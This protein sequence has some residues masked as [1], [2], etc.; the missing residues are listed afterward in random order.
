MQGATADFNRVGNAA[1]TVLKE[2]PAQ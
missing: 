1:A 2:F